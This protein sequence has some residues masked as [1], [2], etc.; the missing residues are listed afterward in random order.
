MTTT[1]I[2]VAGTGIMALLNQYLQTGSAANQEQGNHPQKNQQRH[3]QQNKPF[4]AAI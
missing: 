1:T 2:G 3:K 4:G